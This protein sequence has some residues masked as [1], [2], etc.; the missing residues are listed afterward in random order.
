MVFSWWRRRRRQKLLAQPF[1]ASWLEILNRNVAHYGLLSEAEQARLRDD[2]RVFIAEK[3]WEGCGGLA[4][5]DEIKVTIAAQACLLLLAIEHDYFSRVMSILV[6]P[7][8][9]AAPVERMEHGWIVEGESDRL[10]E[11]W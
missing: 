8:K 6:Y 4:I 5:T 11:A 7:T 3:H 10:G 2:L 1:P 9:Y